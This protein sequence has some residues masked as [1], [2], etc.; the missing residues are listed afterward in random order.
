M[1]KL[2]TILIATVL[3]LT[4]CASTNEGEVATT[5]EQAEPN[6]QEA[7]PEAGPPQAGARVAGAQHART[8]TIAANPGFEVTGDAR[9]EESADGGT[10]V[11]IEIEGAPSDAILPWHLHEGACGSGGP[12]VGDPTAYPPLSTGLNGE[13]SAEATI[14]VT[15]DPAADYHINVHKSPSETETIVACGEVPKS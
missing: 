7:P 9:V 10:H 8:V 2:P 11:G 6:E 3:V 13:A 1:K 5:T 4:A 14:A 12:I 15:V